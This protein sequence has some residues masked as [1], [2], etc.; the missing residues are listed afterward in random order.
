MK[1]CFLV[2]GL[3]LAGLPA[4]GIAAGQSATQ[5]PVDSA[6]REASVADRT[7]DA[8]S[9]LRD[10]H[11]LRET[12]SNITASRNQRQRL[13]RGPDARADRCAPV[14]GRSYTR[15]DLQRTG[16]FGLHDALRRLDPA[17]Y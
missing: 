13:R 15:E 6:T 9:S 7:S 17:V 5:A 8:A 3:L 11:C 14:S 10:R 12:G 2:I 16:A 1:S 4:A